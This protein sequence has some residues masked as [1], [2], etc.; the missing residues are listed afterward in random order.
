MAT[1]DKCVIA[2]QGW[3]K[4]GREGGRTKVNILSE[5]RR[6]LGSRGPGLVLGLGPGHLVPQ[7]VR[8]WVGRGGCG[9]RA[10]PQLGGRHL[11][12]PHPMCG[13]VTRL[14]G[15]SRVVGHLLGR[16][17][18]G[19]RRRPL[20]PSRP[21]PVVPLLGHIPLPPPFCVRPLSFR[22]ST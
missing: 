7:S 2:P 8:F 18:G 19:G 10:L 15:P 17:V 13:A 20:R 14:L 3:T 11:L 22:A 16:D 4:G 1:V 5:G 6:G 9:G 12:H 21:P